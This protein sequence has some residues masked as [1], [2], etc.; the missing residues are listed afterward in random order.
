MA[1]YIQARVVHIVPRRVGDDP[2]PKP[3]SGHL[4]SLKDEY[5]KLPLSQVR[6]VCFSRLRSGCGQY[7]P[8][9]LLG[10]F[11]R[12]RAGWGAPKRSSGYL[13]CEQCG[14]ARSMNQARVISMFLSI[15]FAVFHP[16]LA[17]TS[18]HK[19]MKKRFE[20]YGDTALWL[21]IKNNRI[22]QGAS[23]WTLRK[24]MPSFQ[25]GFFSVCCRQNDRKRMQFNQLDRLTAPNVVNH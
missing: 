19:R 16:D 21:C 25:I 24:I 22:T 20:G 18:E 12:F 8:Q 7:A 15:S 14:A 17:P 11:T 5:G 3:D 13:P 9:T 2:L 10:L 1:R 23:C 6:F 4:R